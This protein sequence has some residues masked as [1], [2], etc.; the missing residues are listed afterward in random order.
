[1]KVKTGNKYSERENILH[2][3][4][5]GSVMGTLL[6]LVFRNNLSIYKSELELFSNDVKSLV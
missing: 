3:V 5:Q 2:G 6:F 1:M 4:P